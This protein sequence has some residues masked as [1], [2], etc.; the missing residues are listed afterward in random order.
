MLIIHLGGQYSVSRLAARG[1]GWCT[2]KGWARG[3]VTSSEV[4]RPGRTILT[5]AYWGTSCVSLLL[6]RTSLLFTINLLSNCRA[7]AGCYTS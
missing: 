6:T 5:P 1:W 3:R 7:D 4:S 2:E